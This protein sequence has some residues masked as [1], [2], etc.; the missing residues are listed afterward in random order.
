[1]RSGLLLD[2]SRPDGIDLYGL[3]GGAV[4]DHDGQHGLLRL[5][6]WPVLGDSCSRVLELRVWPL[7]SKHE[8]DQLRR[9]QRRV[10]LGRRCGL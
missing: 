4:R 1:M 8:A 6:Y 10:V 2:N 5:R 9:V 3:L 7:P